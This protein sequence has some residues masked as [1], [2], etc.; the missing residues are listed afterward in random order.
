MGKFNTKFGWKPDVPDLRDFRYSLKPKMTLPSVVNLQEFCP[1]VWD[2]GDIGSCTAQAISAA[3]QCNAIKNNQHSKNIVRSR[4]FIY[5]NERFVEGTV[6]S[7]AGAMI[8]TGIK[9]VAEHGVCNEAM[10]WYNPRKFTVKPSRRCYD[11]ALK[12][13]ALSYFRLPQVVSSMKG[14]LADGFPFIVGVACYSDFLSDQV[15][16]SGT[17]AMPRSDDNLVGGHAVLVVGYDDA[18]Q[19]FV[20]RN[21]WGTSWG[22]KGHGYIPYCYLEHEDL[23]ADLWTIRATE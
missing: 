6:D 7:D 12:Y 10:W 16:L 11:N 23:A 4:L 22:N 18:K 3:L 9:T 8:R 13:Q 1:P 20:F 15:S 21:S 19:S 17:I 5:Y 14:C 2:Q